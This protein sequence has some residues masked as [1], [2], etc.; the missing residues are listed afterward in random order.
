MKKT[1]FFIFIFLVSCSIS[2]YA[3]LKEDFNKEKPSFWKFDEKQNIYTSPPKDKNEV[4][5][6][7]TKYKE[8]LTGKD[9]SFVFNEFGMPSLKEKKRF[10]YFTSSGCDE[11]FHSKK[12]MKSGNFCT[13]IVFDFDDK[14]NLKGITS[15]G[16]IIRSEE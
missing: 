12:E 8:Y 2:Q 13:Y 7:W 15:S 14:Y 3:Q 16:V 4:V 6:F 10:T 9:T 11:I 1:K 5:V